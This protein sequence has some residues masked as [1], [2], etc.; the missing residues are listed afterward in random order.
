MNETEFNQIEPYWTE[1]IQN[2]NKLHG[3]ELN[4]IELNWIELNWT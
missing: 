3:T 4:C 1:L 2:W